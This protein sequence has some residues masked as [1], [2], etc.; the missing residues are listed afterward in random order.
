MAS[1]SPITSSPLSSPPHLASW[2]SVLFVAG[3]RLEK[4]KAAAHGGSVDL[5]SLLVASTQGHLNTQT[6]PFT[7]ASS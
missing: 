4:E 5:A 3:L 2:F 6:V 1:L 7:K